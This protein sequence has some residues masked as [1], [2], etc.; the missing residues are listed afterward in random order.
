MIEEGWKQKDG[1]K[2]VKDTLR[3]EADSVLSVRLSQWLEEED[4]RGSE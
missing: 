2:R 3:R 1:K 4:S